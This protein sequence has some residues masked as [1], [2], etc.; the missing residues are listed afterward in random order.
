MAKTP[1]NYVLKKSKLPSEV[2]APTAGQ[3]VG[4]S[5]GVGSSVPGVDASAM[6]RGSADRFTGPVA[7]G[8][9]G[10]FTC[11]ACGMNLSTQEELDNCCDVLPDPKLKDPSRASRTVQRH[12]KET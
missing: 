1:P 4:L 8:R 6:R 7:C 9:L 10:A 3:S 12:R 5:G 11:P 2:P